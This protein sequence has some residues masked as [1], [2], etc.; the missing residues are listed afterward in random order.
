MGSK[1]SRATDNKIKRSL[2]SN[3][4]DQVKAKLLSNE[5]IR[6]FINKKKIF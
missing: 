2:T 4:K 6:N 3:N 1:S 5:K